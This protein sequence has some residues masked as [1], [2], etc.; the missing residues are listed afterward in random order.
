M[1]DK[2]VPGLLWSQTVEQYNDQYFHPELYT[3]ND[4][5]R[6]ITKQDTN[7]NTIFNEILNLV[8][9]TDI[10]EKTGLSLTE[11]CELDYYSFDQIRT[12][13]KLDELRKR[14]ALGDIEKT[15][16]QKTKRRRSAS[17]HNGSVDINALSKRR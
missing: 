12:R 9:T 15:S 1:F 10:C 7:R 6:F 14:E 13:I 4:G 8:F 5:F 17:L 11:L 2:D 3:V 16:A